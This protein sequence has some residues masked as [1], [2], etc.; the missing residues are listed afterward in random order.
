MI[1]GLPAVTTPLFFTAKAALIARGLPAPS[2]EGVVGLF[3]KHVIQVGLFEAKPG[4]ALRRTHDARLTG[5]YAVGIPVSREE[6][7]DLL[8]VAW[9]FVAEVRAALEREGTQPAE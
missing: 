7:E 9:E 5:D 8:N 1:P 6:A 4:R 2:H 3:G